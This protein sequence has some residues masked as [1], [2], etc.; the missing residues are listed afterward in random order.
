MGWKISRGCLTSYPVQRKLHAAWHVPS[1]AA[2]SE[3]DKGKKVET[4]KRT[5]NTR[6]ENNQKP[7]AVSNIL[8]R[9]CFLSSN[10]KQQ[11]ENKKDSQKEKQER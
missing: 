10:E 1:K 8:L 5:R 9:T 11:K 6:R 2:T 7:Q 3:Y 4:S